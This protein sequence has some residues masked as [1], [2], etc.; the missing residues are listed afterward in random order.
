MDNKDRQ[1][2]VEQF[3]ALISKAA[4]TPELD[5]CL[6]FLKNSILLLAYETWG[7]QRVKDECKEQDATNHYK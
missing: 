1:A 3:V 5:D 2:R 4:V 7:E 6:T